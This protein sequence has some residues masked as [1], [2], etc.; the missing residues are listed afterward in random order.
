MHGKSYDKIAAKRASNCIEKMGRH[1]W[2]ECMKV[3]QAF[4]G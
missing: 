4:N 3:N 1:G 2:G